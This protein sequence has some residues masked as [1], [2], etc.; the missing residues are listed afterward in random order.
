MGPVE[1]A[2]PSPSRGLAM[3]EKRDI[4]G[5]LVAEQSRGRRE[6]PGRLGPGLRQAHARPGDLRPG[7]GA[8]RFRRDCWR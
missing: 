8:S 5:V 7:E 6:E 2:G 4:V 1:G 3:H